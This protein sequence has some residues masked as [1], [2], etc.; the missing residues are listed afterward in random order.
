[1]LLE[2]PHQLLELLHLGFGGGVVHALAVVDVLALQ[3]VAEG[4]ADLVSLD[5][6]V[7]FTL[8]QRAVL[9]DGPGEP[10][11]VTDVELIMDAQVG[12]Q[13]F[14]RGCNVAVDHY[15]IEQPGVD[16]FQQVLGLKVLVGRLEVD[17]LQPP[18][19]E[20]LVELDQVLEVTAGRPH[21]DRQPSQILELA[22]RLADRTGDHDLTYLRRKGIGKVHRQQPA[23]GDRQS[24]RGDVAHAF[25]QLRHQ[26]IAD[27]GN[28]QHAPLQ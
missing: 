5:E 28:E 27:H 18:F 11:I 26:L 15:G 23:F 2:Q 7:Q 4:R 14:P 24:T 10:T 8:Q 17:G 6:G 25:Q 13:Q 21:R 22:H 3:Q 9:A 19:L 20:T 1:M 16:H 12:K